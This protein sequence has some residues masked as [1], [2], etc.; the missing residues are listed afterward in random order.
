MKLKAKILI[1]TNSILLIPILLY[2]IFWIVLTFIL[3]VNGEASNV[4]II[5]FLGLVAVLLFSIYNAVKL[6]LTILK[7]TGDNF[8][9][10]V[11]KEYWSATF[12]NMGGYMV[13]YPIILGLIFGMAPAIGG[14]FMIIALFVSLPMLRKVLKTKN[15]Y[16]NLKRQLKI[17][18]SW[19]PNCHVSL[20]WREKKQEWVCY[21]CLAKNNYQGKYPFLMEWL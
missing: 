17:G 21:K 10:P 14:I 18:K 3:F 19:C 15:R 5:L 1:L 8:L 11:K 4:L 20:F 12:V 6:K 13:F 2:L 9:Q 16:K 7:E